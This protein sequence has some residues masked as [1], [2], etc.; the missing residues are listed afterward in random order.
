MKLQCNLTL[1]TKI[2]S[3]WLKDLNIRHDTIKHLEEN[4]GKTL[5]DIN[6]TNGLLGQFPKATEIKTNKQ[7]KKQMVPNQT[8]K[9]W[10]RNRNH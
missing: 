4:M 10:N 7:T 8:Y 1:C 2:N 6:C 3:Q 9:F 5:S